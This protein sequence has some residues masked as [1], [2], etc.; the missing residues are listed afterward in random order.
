MQFADDRY[1]DELV[2]VYGRGSAGDARYKRFHQDAAVQAAGDA[3]VNAS[4]KWQATLCNARAVVAA[5]PQ[6]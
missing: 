2:R 6:P 1:Q 5:H 3:F 4:R